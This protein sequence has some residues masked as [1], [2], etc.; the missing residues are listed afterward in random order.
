MTHNL[1]DFRVKRVVIEAPKWTFNDYGPILLT[2][3]ILLFTAVIGFA[4]KIGWI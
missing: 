1:R 3:L 2:I 4:H